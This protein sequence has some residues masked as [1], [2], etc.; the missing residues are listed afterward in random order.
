[1]NYTLDE[2]VRD[3]QV[4]FVLINPLENDLVI[5]LLVLVGRHEVDSVL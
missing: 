5:L 3:Q 4:K 2:L 1:M